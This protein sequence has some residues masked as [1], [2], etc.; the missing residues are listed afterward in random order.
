MAGHLLHLPLLLLLLPLQLLLLL[1][2]ELLIL[3][4]LLKLTFTQLVLVFTLLHLFFEVTRARH[5]IFIGF[6]EL[7]LSG[8]V[9]TI[10]I[11]KVA[12]LLVHLPQLMLQL[13]DCLATLLNL[14]LD[15]A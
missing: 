3:H 6:P 8:G 13:L 2:E 11:L 7:A 1:Q 14:V 4:R 10:L 5:L 9:F 15:P 12:D